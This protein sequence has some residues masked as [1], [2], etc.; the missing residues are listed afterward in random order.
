MFDAG[1][2][3]DQKWRACLLEV[4]ND[5]GKRWRGL[6]IAEILLMLEKEI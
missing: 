2:R 5:T 3:H 4:D 1:G 6:S